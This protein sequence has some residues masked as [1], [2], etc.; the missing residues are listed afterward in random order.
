MTGKHGRL[1]TFNY[2]TPEIPAK[3]ED[4]KECMN[5]QD[6]IYPVYNGGNGLWECPSCGEDPEPEDDDTFTI[7]GFAGDDNAF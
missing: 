1:A 4:M 7:R 5:C 6:A 2:S 3:T